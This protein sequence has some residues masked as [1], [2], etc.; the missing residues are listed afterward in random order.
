MNTS[1]GVNLKDRTSNSSTIPVTSANSCSVYPYS[2]VD[3][4]V[5]PVVDKYP[6]LKVNTDSNSGSWRTIISWIEFCTLSVLLTWTKYLAK[7]FQI[8]LSL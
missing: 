3:V 1:L 2:L 5:I 6:F 8:H 4:F 7:S